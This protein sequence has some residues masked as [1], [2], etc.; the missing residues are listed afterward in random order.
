MRSVPRKHTKKEKNFTKNWF[1][2]LFVSIRREREQV[3]KFIKSLYNFALSVILMREHIYQSSNGLK[4]T[5][6]WVFF[7]NNRFSLNACV[8]LG[9]QQQ[10]ILPYKGRLNGN[11]MKL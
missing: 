1:G 11:K 3:T 5:I 4:T 2:R 10:P 8:C 6:K 7:E 9:N